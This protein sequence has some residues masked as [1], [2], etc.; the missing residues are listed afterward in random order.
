MKEPTPVRIDKGP[1]TGR[2]TRE[3]RR[4]AVRADE[5]CSVVVRYFGR[6]RPQRVYPLAVEVTRA[7]RT[8]GG[9]GSLPAVVRPIIPGALVVPSEEPIDASVP[10]SR[11][12][13]QIT[14]LARRRLPDARIEVHQKGRPVQEVALDM[15]VTT[16]RL[17]WVLLALAVLVPWGL[18]RMAS[19]PLSGDVFRLPSARAKEPAAPQAPKA[20]DGERQGAG[21]ANEELVSRAAF[22]PEAEFLPAPRLAAEDPKSLHAEAAAFLV[23]LQSA[24]QPKGGAKDGGTPKGGAKDGG[25][26]KGGPMEGGMPKGG[27]MGGGMPMGGP[28]GGP[29]AE[30]AGRTIP[31]VRPG[32]PDEVLRDRFRTWAHTTL[33][34]M[35][36]VSKLIANDAY[37]RD[38]HHDRR[39]PEGV[40]DA[41]GEVVYNDLASW[42]SFL[43]RWILTLTQDGLALYVG[44]VLL[45]LSFIAWLMHRAAR[46]YQHASLVFAAHPSDARTETSP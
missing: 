2:E 39:R 21:L 8:E 13:F 43:Y 14:P 16:Q 40:E 1:S 45:A 38:F 24:A 18:T 32:S 42:I 12:V 29:P 28:P 5:P 27:P 25:M 9:A 23:L 26:P 22:R 3:A 15:R 17:A 6:M 46:A 41:W 35:G 44:L 10:G 34:D 37:G 4:P 33:P 7:H 31:D 19:A 11:V 30:G 20:K 36:R